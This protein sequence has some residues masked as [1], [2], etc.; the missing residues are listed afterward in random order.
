MANNYGPT[1][2]PLLTDASAE[3]TEAIFDASGYTALTFYVKGS[4]DSLSAG[5]VTIE[6]ADYNPQA[7]G[8][9]AG[10]WSSIGTVNATAVANLAQQAYHVGG[11]GG[12]Y[13]FGLV[14]ARISTAVTGGTV[15]V[16]LRAV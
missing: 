9:Y 5:V 16:V 15:S 13:A 1:R 8:P 10:T 2:V 14:R 11:P 12:Q 4:D 3:G 7:E 6:E